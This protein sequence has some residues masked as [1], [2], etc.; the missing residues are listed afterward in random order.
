MSSATGPVTLD[1]DLVALAQAGD[2]A[3][4]EEVLRQV[5]PL[6]VRR[7]SR[8]L[9][10]ADDAEEAAQDALVAIA[11]NITGFAGTGSFLGWVTVIA[12][13]CARAT[14]RRLRRRFVELGDVD[15]PEPVEPR[16]TSV[17]AG[18]RLDLMDA[19][20]ELE[21][22]KPHAVEAFVLRDLGSLSYAEIAAVTGTTVTT[23]RDRIHV[24]RTFIPPPSA[25]RSVTG[26]TP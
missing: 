13:N 19:L 23:V 3:A 8:F 5:R 11:R 10:Y 26:V 17:V 15:H 14:Y 1:D 16:T 21:A 7:C 24:A 20:D 12:S 9:P 2:A 18:T 22:A 4:L 25:W 6:V